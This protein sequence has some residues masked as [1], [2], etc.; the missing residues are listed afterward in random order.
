MTKLKE[1][2]DLYHEQKALD[3][4]SESLQKSI[5]LSAAIEIIEKHGNAFKNA[6]INGWDWDE[7]KTLRLVIEFNA[8]KI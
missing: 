8:E 7:D 5:S 4:K 1:M 3:E 6:G 2:N